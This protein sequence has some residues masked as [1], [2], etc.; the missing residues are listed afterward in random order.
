MPRMEQTP[1]PPD[2]VTFKRSHFYSVLVVI[3]F[4]VGILV[5]YM[6]WGR[7]SGSSPTAANNNPPAATE[8]AFRRFDIPTEGF[9][10]IGPKDA[11]IVIVEF[12]DY[13][14]PYCQRWHDQVYEP[15]M[16]AYPGKIRFVY[17]NF[18]LTQIHP[19]AMN[20]AEASL[21]AGEQ[22]A[23]WQYHGKLFDNYDVLSDDLY[24]SLATDLGLDVTAFQACMTEHRYKD[25]IEAD[26]SFS[27]NLG[28]QSTPTFFINGIPVIGA[29]P[30]IEFQTKIDNELAGNYPK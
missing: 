18:P 26:M 6:A 16:A 30:L 5:G 19:Q 24:A 10:S 2:T 21:C 22:D 23:Y 12:S 17:R 7:G 15:L 27:L 29:Q 11:P 20:A 25:E 28:I 1:T 4:A 14:C 9:P 13:Q 8:Q 3:A